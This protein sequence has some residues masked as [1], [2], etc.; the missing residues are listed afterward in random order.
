MTAL[1]KTKIAFAALEEKK[2][3]NAKIL[4]VDDLTTLTEYFVVA[5]GTSSTHVRSLADEVEFKLSESGQQV[6]HIEGRGT[7]WLLLDYRDVLVHVFTQAA[8]EEYS[9]EKLWSDA[10][11]V[12]FQ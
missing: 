1:E 2:A 8:R 11:E 7:G 12:T 10:Q 9:I 5:H 3:V 6:H 4:K